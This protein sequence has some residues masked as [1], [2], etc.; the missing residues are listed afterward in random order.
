MAV[1]DAVAVARI[2]PSMRRALL[3]IQ[4]HPDGEMV[5]E[6]GRCYV[7]ETRFAAS[8]FYLLVRCMVL[9]NESGKPGEFER[10]TLNETGR[11]TLAAL[12]REEG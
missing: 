12:S 3:A 1:E 6:R 5:F 7:G 8:T 2:R 10:W 9:R 11:A 4:A